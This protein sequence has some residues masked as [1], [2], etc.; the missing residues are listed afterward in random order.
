MLP[1]KEEVK[2][3]LEQL[4]NDAS[5]EDIQYHIYIR[6]NVDHGLNEVDAGKTFSGE[7]FDKR[8]SWWLPVRQ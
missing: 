5:L 8:M 1:A 4:P 3:I 2:H 6:Q 7:E